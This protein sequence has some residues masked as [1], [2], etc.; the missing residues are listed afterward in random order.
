GRA[1]V[2]PGVAL[3]TLV[4]WLARLG[5]RNEPASLLSGIGIVSCDEALSA[6]R[7]APDGDAGHD[8]I[9]IGQW[10]GRNRVPGHIGRNRR[11]PLQGTRRGRNRD[12]VGVRRS[13]EDLIAKDGDAPIGHYTE[14]V[15][16]AHRDRAR[17]LMIVGPYLFPRG[18][19]QRQDSAG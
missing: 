14:V 15:D 19:V 4:A 13:K 17:R 18:R 8:E 9:A 6:G 3:P 7:A 11:F 16:V 5:D 2:T 1:S 12:E 10:R